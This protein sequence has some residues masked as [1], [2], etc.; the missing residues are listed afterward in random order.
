[1]NQAAALNLQQLKDLNPHA[2]SG[3]KVI[4]ALNTKKT[5][6]TT[7]QVAKRHRVFGLNKLKEQQPYSI[8]H[9]IVSQFSDI[10]IILLV[11][12]GL[13]SIL[14]G[15]WI[16]GLAIFTIVL[17]NGVLGFV[18][19]YKAEQSLEAL[20]K[21]ETQQAVVM[22]NNKEQTI[23]AQKVVPGDILILTEGEKI[24]ADARLLETAS[25]RI[26]E[27]NLTGES[28]PVA[29][30]C[31]AVSAQTGLPDRTNMVFAGCLVTR[32]RGQAVAVLTGMHT[33]IGRIAQ[34]IHQT[35]TETTPLQKALNKLGRLLGVISLAVAIPGLI[36]GLLF[37][38]DWVEMIMMTIS[39]AVSAIPEG[40]PIVVTIALAL[41]IKKMV[42]VNVLVRRL[43]TAESL[44]GTDVICSDKTGTIT[45]NEMTVNTIVLH[46]GGFF[47]VTGRGYRS[48]GEIKSAKTLSKKFGFK[49]NRSG[50]RQLKNLLKDLVLCADATLDVG[51]PTER[52]LIAVAQKDGIK[53]DKLRNR[54]QRVDEIPFDSAKKFMAVTVKVDGKEKAIVKGA[55]E[56]I[57]KMCDLSKA[58]K[59]KA[60][61]VN[62]HLTSKGLRVL[63]VAEKP[64]TG[65]S[66]MAGL[67]NYQCLGLVAMADP[68]R[69]EVAEALQV[70][71]Q[72]GI[73][74]IMITGDHKQ[75]AQAVAEEIGLVS[76][77]AVTGEDLDKMSHQE[78]LKIVK[79]VNVFA[80]VSPKH[81]VRILT[82]LQN[83]G[84]QVAMTGD[85]VNDAPAVKKADVGIAVGAGTDLTKGI[86]DM[87]LLDNNFASIPAAIR[88]GRR[89]FF[90]IKK[91]VRFLI[92]AN[93]D[94]IA[95]IFSAI[96]LGLPLPMIPM[97]IL[98][99]NLA[100]DSLPALA[101]A[102][103]V[104]DNH[105]MSRK[106]YEPK[107][108]I[109]R[110]V[111][112]FSILAALVAYLITFGLFLLVYQVLG[113]SLKYA[114]TLTFT[115]TVFFE[116]FLVFAIRS[117]KN[118]WEIGLFNN[119]LLWWSVLV[120][121]LGQLFAVYT[122]I[123]QR[124]FDT[125]ALQWQDW[126]LVLFL[127]SAGFTV[128]E[129]L[130]FVKAEAPALSKLI[131]IG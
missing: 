124:I 42:K 78:F 32:G 49:T 84:L 104:A 38:R 128:I 20:K 93:F 8:W 57:F 70:C 55:P 121:A 98:W 64:L 60:Q 58:A 65:K 3:P 77:G 120:G 29:K 116:F 91:F 44:G 14:I 51:D 101:L 97:Q 41:G 28:Q 112:P 73:R 75:T 109:L 59:K 2:I 40:L 17:I 62:N 22:R 79:K 21:I 36:L 47:K 85:G 30:D 50:K 5:G 117:E 16:D 95:G 96:L 107:Q 19:E 110:G 76:Q 10:L 34:E 90:N 56:V 83:L 92:S 18:Q 118:A 31:Q 63:A 129:F 74:V 87:I 99:L 114:R 113:L 37:G 94:E 102:T 52:A 130:K 123:G 1:M 127:A 43:A 33:Q 46:Q 45:H 27:S 35:T 15:E 4:E 68:A 71:Y 82:T 81:K 53:T 54:Y 89:I 13:F 119:K 115:T 100:T 122:P 25:L 105:L 86:S 48:K 106:P 111:I 11:L 12:A 72:A 108:E 6:L 24:P 61:A 66:K 103:D 9:L 39:L 126:L 26:D 23:D 125:V 131:P 69:Q 88:E 80:R 67:K 7:Q